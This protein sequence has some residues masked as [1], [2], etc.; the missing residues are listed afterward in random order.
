MA[1]IVSLRVAHATPELP[2]GTQSDQL[3]TACH[4]CGTQRANKATLQLRTCQPPKSAAV[5]RTPSVTWP[6]VFCSMAK[7]FPQDA[8]QKGLVLGPFGPV[9]VWALGANR[10]EP[11][12]L[13]EPIPKIACIVG[14]YF[15]AYSYTYMSMSIPLVVA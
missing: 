3:E 15:L 10:P 5:F 14:A 11:I 4:H 9:P 13:S 6:Y 8:P 1:D 7:S 12:S 2:N